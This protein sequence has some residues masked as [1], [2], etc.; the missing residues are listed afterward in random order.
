MPDPTT[1]LKPNPI[2]PENDCFT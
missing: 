2:A 1:F